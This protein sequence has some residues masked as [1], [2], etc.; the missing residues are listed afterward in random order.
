[1]KRQIERFEKGLPLED[2]DLV[3]EILHSTLDPSLWTHCYYDWDVY[4]RKNLYGGIDIQGEQGRLK[5]LIWLR[6][7]H[8]PHHIHLIGHIAI[9]VWMIMLGIHHLHEVIEFQEEKEM[10]MIKLE[11]RNIL[12]KLIL[13]EK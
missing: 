5:V 3:Q 4:A 10:N 8:I 1:M 13:V 11:Q 7:I 2:P 12:K 9:M 6:K